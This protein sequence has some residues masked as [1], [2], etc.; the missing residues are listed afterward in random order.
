MAGVGQC[1]THGCVLLIDPRAVVLGF[2][3]SAKLQS[4]IGFC[5]N[6]YIGQTPQQLSDSLEMGRMEMGED[7]LVC[8]EPAGRD[9]N[10][11]VT[12]YRGCGYLYSSRHGKHGLA[13]YCVDCG[14]WGMDDLDAEDNVAI[15]AALELSGFGRCFLSVD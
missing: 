4:Q 5:A 7:Y 10:G 9:Q 2:R 13:D 14:E 1:I 15:V 11:K 12:M 6:C 8:I 3:V